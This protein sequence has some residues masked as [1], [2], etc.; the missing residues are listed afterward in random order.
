MTLHHRG[1]PGA[2]FPQT[3]HGNSA[4]CLKYNKC[5]LWSLSKS[6]IFSHESGWLCTSLD[7][8]WKMLCH[9][10]LNTKE[11]LL[12][13]EHMLCTDKFL[14][15]PVIFNPQSNLRDRYFSP[16]FKEL[17]LWHLDPDLSG[18]KAQSFSSVPSKSKSASLFSYK[19][20]N[21]LYKETHQNIKLPH[22][23]KPYA[24]VKGPETRVVRA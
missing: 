19:S 13:I 17:I 20:P 23:V 7:C 16:F 3:D 18:F 2:I 12:F 21:R 24:K 8:K 22:K 14:F 9:C 11:L 4:L 1:G 6:L 10:L 5:F 15:Y